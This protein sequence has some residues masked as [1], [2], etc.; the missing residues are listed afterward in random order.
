MGEPALKR[1]SFQ[2]YLAA[3]EASEE[4]HEYFDGHILA[5]AGGSLNHDAMSVEVA[6][7]LRDLLRGRPCGVQGPNARVRI[8]ATGLATYP[9]ASVWCGHRE[10]DPEHRHT[11]VNPVLIV[12]VLSKGTEAY[13]RGEKFD[14]YRQI[15]SLREYLLVSV[16]KHQV[17][18]FERQED[19]NWLFR[20][21]GDGESVP[22]SCASGT[23]S[24]TE[25]YRVVTPELDNSAA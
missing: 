21:Y 19:G 5:M 1:F 14:H 13:D 8:L 18:R 3:E 6:G 20:S 10:T 25:L 9:D 7:V 12:E 23:L 16:E 22:I 17:E 2:E 4:R 24:V 11:Y 15:P